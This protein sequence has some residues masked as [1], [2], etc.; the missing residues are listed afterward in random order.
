MLLKSLKLKDFRQFKGEQEITFSTDPIR[1]VTVIM[2]ENG[3]GKTTLAQAFTWCLYGDT[4]F[5]DKSMLCKATAQ[6]M[7]PGNEEKVRVELALKHN[8]IEY[9]CIREQLYSKD[10]SGSIRRHNQTTFKIAYKNTDGQR[11]YVPDGETELRM[12]EIL[13]KELS[14]YFF[15]DGER[16][17]NMSKE[18]RKGKSA[19]FAQAV[20]SLLGLSAFQSALDHL[21]GR[22]SV[23]KMYN[24]SYDTKSDSKIA[25][26]T[27]EIEEYEKKLQTIEERLAAIAG[28][29]TIATRFHRPAGE[30]RLSER[31]GLPHL[32][33]WH[34][35]RAVHPF[36]AGRQPAAALYRRRDPA[37]RAGAGGR[38]GA[39]QALPH[40]VVGLQRLPLQHRR[41]YLPGVLPFVGRGHRCGD[42]GRSPRDRR[43][44]GDGPPDGGLRPHV[45]P[46]RLLR[47]RCGGDRLCGL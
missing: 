43:P 26:Y 2:G 15:F 9:L 33:L 41:I 10:N 20:R 42:E 6:S 32:R 19:E 5:D 27:K 3:S 35:H 31:P 14:K 1:N 34:D 16:I 29:E 12:K 23:I 7:L 38:L 18:I 21:G 13:P 46:V 17:G 37:Q 44:C 36:A 4:D 24:E 30:P 8:N 22:N 39:L 28:E 45:H 11:E 25:Q 47:R 40:P